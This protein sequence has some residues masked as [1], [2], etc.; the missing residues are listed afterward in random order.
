MADATNL[1]RKPLAAIRC[2]DAAR[3]ES[4]AIHGRARWRHLS[5]GTATSAYCCSADATNLHRKP[6]A[7]IRC[8]DA[9][10]FESVA[11]H[12]R[13]RW[14]HLSAG[15]ATAL[16]GG[17]LRFSIGDRRHRRSRI[18]QPS[19]GG[20]DAH[21]SLL[22]GRRERR[23]D[24]GVVAVR[25]KAIVAVRKQHV[26]GEISGGVGPKHR[27][28][29]VN[30]RAVQARRIRR[31]ARSAHRGSRRAG[32]GP[33]VQ[34]RNAARARRCM[35][36]VAS[37][38]VSERMAEAAEHRPR[39]YAQYHARAKSQPGLGSGRN[40]K[41]QSD[42]AKDGNRPG[43][44]DRS[45][46]HCR[47]LLKRTVHRQG[48]TPE[49]GKV[50]PL[51]RSG[52]GGRANFAGLQLLHLRE[53]RWKSLDPPLRQTIKSHLAYVNLTDAF[54][55]TNVLSISG[56]SGLM[57]NC[58]ASGRPLANW[59]TNS[60][61][62]SPGTDIELKVRGFTPA[63]LFCMAASPLTDRN[64]PPRESPVYIQAY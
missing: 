62:E 8:R 6:L 38:G 33:P 63:D 52:I 53:P 46:A 1:H 26:I 59:G 22:L 60:S 18:A 34:A 56:Q 23:V 32:R 47:T 44:H 13:A 20:P 21:S 7:A 28:C 5:A 55:K 10:R 48:R 11:I 15:T 17:F 50:S 3:F 12:G 31:G 58:S 35:Y 14:R 29:P 45:P 64:E 40:G 43:A 54:F 2:R 25:P 4:V 42:H 57:P 61:S 37:V 24:D 16:G 51:R 19:G 30:R 49:F 41:G 9:A 39:D 36:C 27:C